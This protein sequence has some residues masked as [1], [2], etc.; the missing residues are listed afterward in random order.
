M[1]RARFALLWV[2]AGVLAVALTLASGYAL[3]ADAPAP[4]LPI[5]N[6]ECIPCP[7]GGAR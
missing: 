5:P 4:R 6:A 7:P 3:A 2:T 1:N